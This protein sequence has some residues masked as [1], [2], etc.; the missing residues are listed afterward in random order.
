MVRRVGS[1]TLYTS[2]RVD[3]LVDALLE[4]MVGEPLP[5][6]QREIVLVQSRGLSRYLELELAK[7][8]SIAASLEM[9][10]VGSYLQ[11]LCGHTDRDDAWS[12]AALTLR[13]FR[14]LGK[15]DLAKTLGAASDYV[16]D[17]GN[18][19]KRLALAE[20]L[21][22]RFDDYQLYRPDFLRQFAAGKHPDLEHADWQQKLWRM[23]LD[24]CDPSAESAHR[25]D[26][27][28][29]KLDR[30][31]IDGMR[32]PTRISVFGVSTMPLPKR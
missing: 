12:K 20:A 21:A 23:L 14:I 3:S 8:Q 31:E 7:K 5:P 22:Q 24:E 1:W 10:F 4:R 2:N 9:P 29:R 19:K 30:R 18:Q 11:R 16:Q 32:L 13:I 26:A 17:D 15:P 6:L 27:L 28:Q 25:I